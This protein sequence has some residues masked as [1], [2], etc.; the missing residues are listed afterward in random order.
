MVLPKEM[1]L[2]GHKCFDYIHKHGNRY[3]GSSMVL[4]VSTAKEHLINPSPKKIKAYYLKCAISISNKV[5]KKAVTRNRLRRLLHNHLRERLFCN[6]E[7][8]ISNNWALLSLFPNCLDKDPKNLLKE[9]DQL[10][11]QAG[12]YSS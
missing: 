2:R 12:F 9:F 1:R 10:L 8:G 6:K 3:K 11:T 4:K 5:S 7:L